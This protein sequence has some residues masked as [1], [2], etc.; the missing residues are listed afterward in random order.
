MKL[1]LSFDIGIILS[2][3]GIFFYGCGQSYLAAYM[4]VFYIDPIT[5]NF[6]TIDK[7]LWG[8]LNCA[9]ILSILTIVCLGLFFLTLIFHHF[10]IPLHLFKNTKSSDL[11]TLKPYGKSNSELER[12]IRLNKILNIILFLLFTILAFFTFASIDIE[13][14]D[15]AKRAL[16]NYKGLPILTVKDNKNYEGNVHLIK[17]G[18]S[19]CAVIDDKKNVS[20]VE[21]KNI[22]MMGSNFPINNRS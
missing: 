1:N 9:N 21:P 12:S 17:C 20:F 15:K 2:F 18:L 3:L 19:L 6:P 8:F 14:T 13:T 7:I 4:A 11:V 22:T 16:L 10:H 5:L